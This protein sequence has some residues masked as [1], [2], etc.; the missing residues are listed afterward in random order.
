M[1]V[2]LHHGHMTCMS[3]GRADF[4]WQVHLVR[5]IQMLRMGRMSWHGQVEL[6]HWVVGHARGTA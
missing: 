1:H 4:L 5:L 2:A 6:V 3:A